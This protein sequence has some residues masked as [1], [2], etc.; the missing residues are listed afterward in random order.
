MRFQ[1]LSHAGLLVE[2]SGVSLVSDPWLVGATYWRSWWNYPPV[3]RELVASLRPDYIY[4]T[5]VHWDHFQGPSLRKFPKSTP[6]LV[7][8][9]HYDRMRR[10]LE[11]MGFTTVRELRH[12]ETVDLAPGFRLTSYQFNVFLDSAVVIECDGTTVL[13]SNDAKFMGPPL[14]QIFTR[15]PQIDFVLRSHS[16]AN[17]RLCY[18]IVDAP[19]APLDDAT[20][21]LNSFAAFAQASGA[22]YAIPF[23]SNHCFLHRETYGFN[24]TVQTPRMVEDFFRSRGITRP[25]VKTMVSGDRWSSEEGFQI[26]PLSSD[27]FDHR[28]ER[29]E[30]YRLEKAEVLEKFYAREARATLPLIEV[31]TYFSNLFAALPA[32]VRFLFRGHPIVYVLSAGDRQFLFEVDVYARRVRAIVESERGRTPLLE[33]H[34]SALVF[35]QCM[36]LGL[37]SHLPISKRVRYRVTTAT[38]RHMHFYNLLFNLFEYELLPLRRLASARFLTTW[39]SRWRELLLYSRI[40]VDVA[41]GRGVRPDKYIAEAAVSDSGLAGKRKRRAVTRWRRL[42]AQPAPRR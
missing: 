35:R 32:P 12:G 34:T 13:N 39:S 21:Y 5:H 9:G 11:A 18:E 6:I 42:A 26:S 41:L 1:I 7:P 2:G 29:I 28:A 37:F 38:K 25:E 19:L 36:A 14:H 30:R 15:H 16:S 8:R 40:G 24:D 31:Q 20:R 17:S 3:S 33:I 4:V 23:A 22:R 27:Y 10:D